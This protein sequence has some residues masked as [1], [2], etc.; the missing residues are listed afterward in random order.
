[1]STTDPR[2]RL[3]R[4]GERI[5]LEH[6]QRRGYRLISANHRT[7]HG[8]IDLVVCDATTI[9]FV[10]VKAR[11][12]TGGAGSALD[13]VSPAKRRQVRRIARAWLADEVA[14]RPHLRDIRFD[15]V[16]VTFDRDGRL[17]CLDHVE[18]A[19]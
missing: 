9:V 12:I 18:S 10:E 3:A 2:S 17:L 6:L 7:R 14:A 8:E 1:M 19:F 15:V 11:T 4:R 5:A 13:A 16:G